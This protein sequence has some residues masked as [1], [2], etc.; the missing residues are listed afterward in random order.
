M[1]ER[2][3]GRIGIID[4]QSQTRGSFGHA[5]PRE[6]RRYVSSQL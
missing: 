5:R 6:R 2:T 4:N 1:N 3:T